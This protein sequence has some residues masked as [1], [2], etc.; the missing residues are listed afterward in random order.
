M[1]PESN[2]IGNEETNVPDPPFDDSVSSETT[3]AGEVL[4]KSNVVS[5]PN[6]R[7]NSSPRTIRQQRFDGLW[8]HSVVTSSGRIFRPNSKY[9]ICVA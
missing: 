5:D 8:H 1:V 6:L 3:S 7:T 2:Y 9:K 4:N